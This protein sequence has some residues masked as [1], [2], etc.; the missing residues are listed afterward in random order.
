MLY[1]HPH[2]GAYFILVSDF[3]PLTLHR[4]PLCELV[5]CFWMLADVAETCQ[6]MPKRTGIFLNWWGFI[7]NWFEES[8]AGK[9]QFLLV[10]GAAKCLLATSKAL[11]GSLGSLLWLCRLHWQ[12]STPLRVVLLYFLQLSLCRSHCSGCVKVA[13]CRGCMRNTIVF[14]QLNIVNRIGVAASRLR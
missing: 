11:Q 5:S 3:N 13:R 7:L 14:L 10:R 9:M 12:F 6:I 2:N 1:V 4:F 8:P